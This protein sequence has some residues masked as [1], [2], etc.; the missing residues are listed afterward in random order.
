MFKYIKS[1][2]DGFDVTRNVEVLRMYS[3]NYKEKVM[4]KDQAYTRRN[5]VV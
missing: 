1:S 2:T 3:R 5:P 4:K